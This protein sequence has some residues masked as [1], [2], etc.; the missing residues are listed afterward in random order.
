MFDIGWSEIA[1]IGA[2]AVVVIGP[3]EMPDAMRKVARFVRA[4]KNVVR[5]FQ[6]Q[7]DEIVQAEEV[8]EIKQQLAK[9]GITDF[10]EQVQRELQNTAEQLQSATALNALDAPTAPVSNP[11]EKPKS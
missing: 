8:K 4:A 2:V 3:K 1:L 7:M 9:A 5:Q 6:H 11:V 10:H